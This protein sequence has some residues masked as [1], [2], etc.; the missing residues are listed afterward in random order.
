MAFIPPKKP[1]RKPMPKLQIPSVLNDSDG[2]LNSQSSDTII[3][4]K[5]ISSNHSNQPPSL[6][7][8]IPNFSNN[9]DI[10]SDN[11]TNA[12]SSTSSN[13]PSSSR[14][15]SDD[16]DKTIYASSRSNNNNPP[17]RPPKPHHLEFD[18]EIGEIKA[19][20]LT[21]IDRLGEGASGEVVKVKH[22][23]SNIIMAKKTMSTSPDPAIH[24]Q[25]LRELSF[26]K[27]CQHHTIVKYFGAFLINENTEIEVCME[28]C[29]GGSLDRIYKQIKRRQGRT[30]EKPLGNIANSV[31][32][33]LEYLHSKKI[34]HRGTFILKIT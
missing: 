12:N 30:G 5:P 16:F 34:I 26:L 7:L 17:P 22:K 21:L 8:S 9:N 24:K 29:E 11:S 31:L 13:R 19:D 15:S 32:Q 4:I 28:F 10:N 3:P 1:Q 18:F 27:Q 14:K 2:Q 25:L 23:F 33:G 6:T 20:D